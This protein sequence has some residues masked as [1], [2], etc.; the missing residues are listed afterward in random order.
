VK[1]HGAL[2][3]N[4]IGNLN[5]VTVIAISKAILFEEVTSTQYIG[6][7]LLVCGTILNKAMDVSRHSSE[8]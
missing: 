6:T 2:M 5:L 8:K 3:Q 7:I 4:I 1:K